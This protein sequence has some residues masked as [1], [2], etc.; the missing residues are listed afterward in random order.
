MRL[1]MKILWGILG[2]IPGIVIITLSMWEIP[3]PSVEIRKSVS[4][5]QFF[6][7]KAKETPS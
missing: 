3:A 1:S 4:T 5:E 2:I 6:K 7:L